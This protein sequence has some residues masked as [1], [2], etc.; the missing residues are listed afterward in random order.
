MNLYQQAKSQAF[1]Q[2]CC[3]DIVHLKILQSY[4]PQAFRPISQ[5][6]DFSQIWHLYKNIANNINFRNRPN[7]EKLISKF[8]K[9]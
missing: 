3:T 8:P 6:Q 5:K 2:F 1:S 4:W 7:S 9:K